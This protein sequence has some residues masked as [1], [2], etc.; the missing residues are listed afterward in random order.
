MAEMSIK[1]HYKSLTS[2]EKTK[3]IFEVCE[4]CSFSI[5]TFYRKLRENSFKPCDEKLVRDYIFNK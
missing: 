2:E 4:L 5:P 1:D 3:F